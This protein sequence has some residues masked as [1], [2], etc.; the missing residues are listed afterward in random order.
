MPALHRN[1]VKFRDLSNQV[2]RVGQHC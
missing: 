1:S 2:A